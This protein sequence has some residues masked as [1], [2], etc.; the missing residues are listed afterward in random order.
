ME[1]QIVELNNRIAE[2][3]LLVSLKTKEMKSIEEKYTERISTL[4]AYLEQLH[5]VIGINPES[6]FLLDTDLVEKL[7]EQKSA[8]DEFLIIPTKLIKPN[9]IE[10]RDTGKE[11]LKKE[12]QKLYLQPK[13]KSDSKYKKFSCS[14]CN[15]KGHKRSH[16]PK[17]LYQ[18]NQ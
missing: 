15:E 8:R 1:Q 18:E 5:S 11:K 17:I 7:E 16:C 13:E 3:A 12:P 4:N 9:L 2:L 6:E 10:R 14:Y